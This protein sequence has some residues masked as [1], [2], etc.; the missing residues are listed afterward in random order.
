[1][2]Q[3]TTEI[4][5]EVIFMKRKKGSRVIFAVFAI[6]VIVVLAFFSLLGENHQ[7]NRVIIG[8][9]TRLKA[10]EYL[11]A[12]EWFSS[13]ATTNLPA[14]EQKVMDFNFLL[15][16]ALL[17][18]YRLVDQ[19]DYKVIVRRSGF[20][21]PWLTDDCVQ[22][23][24]ALSKKGKRGIKEIFHRAK[25][26]ELISDLF[27]VCR[28]KRTWRIKRVVIADPTLKEIY[29]ELRQLDLN[30]YVEV[31]PQGIRFQA[32]QVDP[33][34]LTARQRRLLCYSLSKVERRLNIPSTRTSSFFMGSQ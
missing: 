5:R 20:W 7:I 29:D 6:F 15:E 31:R 4:A 22:V 3:R 12:R 25:D 28:E 17:E 27:V 10:R 13:Q 23:G 33:N 30:A 8:Y 9:F 1:M 16:L 18:R 21:I 34:A 11:E 19:E 14:S 32:V 2:P 26:V 24:V